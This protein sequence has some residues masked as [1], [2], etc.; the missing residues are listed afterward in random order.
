MFKAV[1]SLHL[2]PRYL[3]QGGHTRQSHL[4]HKTRSVC[5]DVVLPTALSPLC[6][7]RRSSVL[8]FK[9]E[10]H[11]G[12]SQFRPERVTSTMTS[13][14][15]YRCR[16]N[17]IRSGAFRAVI[18]TFRTLGCFSPKLFFHYRYYCFLLAK[19]NKSTAKTWQKVDAD[20]TIFRNI[21]CRETASGF[22]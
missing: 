17:R 3:C 18:N 10:A 4:F 6:L 1:N 14:L 21:Y 9:I 19:E 12:F 20:L 2:R 8:R 15:P 22:A 13:F 16:V 11:L 5:T 7:L